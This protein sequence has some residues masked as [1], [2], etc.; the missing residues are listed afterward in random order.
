M[1]PFARFIFGV[2][3]VFLTIQAFLISKSGFGDGYSWIQ[4][5]ALEWWIATAVAWS[6]FWWAGQ[7]PK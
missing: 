4:G 1:R 2:A 5:Q 3:G 7:V 6:I